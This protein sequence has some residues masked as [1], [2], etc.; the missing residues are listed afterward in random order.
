[1]YVRKVQISEKELCKKL[2][3]SHATKFGEILAKT[4]D[5]RR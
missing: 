5:V 4:S 3:K 1:M 2:E